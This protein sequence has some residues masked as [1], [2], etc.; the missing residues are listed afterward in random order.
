MD[1]QKRVRAIETMKN[2][3][4]PHRSGGDTKMVDEHRNQKQKQKFDYNLC[5][6]IVTNCLEM[7]C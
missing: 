4:Q 5:N 6:G 7:I 3:H 2:Y 1:D